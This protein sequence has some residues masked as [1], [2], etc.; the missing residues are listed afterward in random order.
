MA[1]EN[2]G[3]S[4]K[5]FHPFVFFADQAQRAITDSQASAKKFDTISDRA[6]DKGIT[7]EGGGPVEMISGSS[8]T[9]QTLPM[10]EVADS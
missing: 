6:Y 5:Q 3:L 10:R 9:H 2:R 8:S 4:E 7:E 1:G